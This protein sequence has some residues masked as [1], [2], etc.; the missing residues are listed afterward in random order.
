MER[1]NYYELLGISQ[2]ATQEEIKKAYRSKAVQYHPDNNQDTSTTAMFQSIYEAYEVLSDLSLRQKYDNELRKQ[3]RTKFSTAESSSYQTEA[4]KKSSYSYTKTR[5]ESEVDFD[6]WLKE[7][8]K[9]KRNNTDK[10]SL[11]KFKDQILNIFNI[12]EENIIK[13]NE[14]IYY[15]FYDKNESNIKKTY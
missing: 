9:V 15:N 3:N 10:D 6:D 2:T 13:N 12:S 1:Q 4:T 7:Y 14:N 11:L 8:L 5:E